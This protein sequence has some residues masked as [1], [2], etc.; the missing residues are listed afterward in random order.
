MRKV[1][2]YELLSLD[3][4]AEQPEDFIIDFDDVMRENLGRVIATQDSVLLG[5]RTYDDWAA[6]W[7]TAEYEPFAS[8]INGVEKFVATST[9]PAQTWVNTTVIDGGLSEFVSDLKR[10]PGGDI[11]VHGSIALAQSLL[12]RDQVD[13]LRLVI[14]PAV[15][16]HGRKLFDKGLPKRLALTRDVASPSGYLLLDFRVGN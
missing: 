7:P 16:M 8:F 15:H 10:R 6:F 9:T 13:E 2:V 5:R 11:G 4:V 1:V 14:A 12:E 3:G